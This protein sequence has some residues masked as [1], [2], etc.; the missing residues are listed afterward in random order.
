MPALEDAQEVV[1]VT[2]VVGQ[3]KL[4]LDCR[5]R[6]A[7]P[8][9]RSARHVADDV[10]VTYGGKWLV[11]GPPCDVRVVSCPVDEVQVPGEQ[12]QSPVLVDVR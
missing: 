3:G 5:L 4:Q 11:G 1:R 8:I 12:C 10:G 2:R 6:Y 7:G 9:A